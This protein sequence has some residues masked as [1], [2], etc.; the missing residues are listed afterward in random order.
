MDL[1][2]GWHF[3]YYAFLR[4]LCGLITSAKV[5]KQCVD[6]PFPKLP[7]DNCLVTS[8]YSQGNGEHHQ[9]KILFCWVTGCVKT[10]WK[11]ILDAI[12]IILQHLSLLL[13]LCWFWGRAEQFQPKL[14][15]I[16]FNKI[17]ISSLNIGVCLQS[18]SVLLLLWG[19]SNSFNVN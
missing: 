8:N 14:F 17:Y 15:K 11:P 3:V 7:S 6:L 18:V 10:V 1:Q 12:R 13:C 19:P 9:I 16:T 4:V 5:S 2:L